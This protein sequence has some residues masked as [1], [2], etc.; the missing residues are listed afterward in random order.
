MVHRFIFDRLA[1]SLKPGRVAV[2]LGARRTGKTVLLKQLCEKNKGLKTLWLDGEDLDAAEKL[3][4]PRAASLQALVANYDL[5][6]V[7]E[8]QRVPGIGTALKLLVDH[9]PGLRMAVSGSSAFDLRN[10]VGEPLTG[11]SIT[12]P[13]YPLAQLELEGRDALA[14]ARA[15]NRRLVFGSYP[16]VE[17]A[18]SNAE[19]IEVLRELR[20]G[21]LLKDILLLDNIKD[22]LF[23]FQLLRQVAF[24]IGHDISFSEI[25]TNLKAGVKTV[26]RYLEL[27][28][29]THVLFSHTGFSRNLRKEYVK[30]PRFYFWDN[31]IRNVVTANFAMPSAR[32]DMGALWENYI[33]SERR[34]KLSYAGKVANFHF[35][36][37]YDGQEIDLVEEH[38]GK[39]H[40]VECK[41]GRHR[42]KP[43]RAFATEYSDADFTVITPE[44]YLD[45][46]A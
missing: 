36:R 43:P 3:S 18:R 13:L 8:A 39:L 9:C 27:L 29:K 7:D 21:Y 38:G 6:V 26:M 14:A 24:Q 37:T 19:R 22:S 4:V 35:W 33:V 20:D 10:K 32:D 17:L 16:Q 1:K 41:W 25:A 44:N 23:V 34:K 12:F 2:L 15:L 40:G 45:F 30:S 42:A 5:L 28:E 11:R 31:G 46:I